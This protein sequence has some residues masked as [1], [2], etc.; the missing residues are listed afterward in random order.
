MTAFVVF[1]TSVLDP[2]EARIDLPDRS[3]NLVQMYP[4][5]EDEIKL[6]EVE[7]VGKWLDRVDNVYDLR[8]RSVGRRY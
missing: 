4:I 1:A 2:K 7:G 3:I 5:Y 6:I 8:R